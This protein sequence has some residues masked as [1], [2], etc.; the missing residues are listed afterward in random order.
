MYKQYFRTFLL[1]ALLACTACVHTCP[2]Q[3]AAHDK[4]EIIIKLHLLLE[5][6][7]NLEEDGM[8]HAD[9]ERI[10]QAMTFKIKH[11]EATL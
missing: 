11:M 1:S 5:D 7:K 9:A 2:T 4:K 3:L 10:R 8:N 6:V